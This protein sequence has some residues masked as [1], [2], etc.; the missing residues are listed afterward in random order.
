MTESEEACGASAFGGECIYGVTGRVV[1]AGVIDMSATASER[2][3]G[4]EV[5]DF[6]DQRRVDSDGG[7][8]AAGG[9][10]G[11]V[12]NSGDE[13]SGGAAL[14]QGDA[15]AIDGEAEVWSVESGDFDLNAFD[16]G[17]DEAG[18][19]AAT[20]FF[21]E[22]VPRFEGLSEFDVDT[23]G[24]E[25]ADKWAAKFEV[26]A[27][28]GGLDIEVGF[29]E[30]L[31][32][33]I[34]ILP[35][36]VWKQELVMDGSAPVD[37]RFAIGLFPEGGGKCADEELLCEAHAFMWRHFKATEFDESESSGGVVR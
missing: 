14:L 7:M 26:C 16:G 32:D 24:G 5:K 15:D 4:G 13:F 9:A 36:A 19:S 12:A 23:V 21:S 3:S 10:P 27:E 2:A 17:I 20:G 22:D 30:E 35:E 33:V 29:L 31:D 25:G 1:S 34:K 37:Q 18:G 8:E 28:P 6:D 11:A